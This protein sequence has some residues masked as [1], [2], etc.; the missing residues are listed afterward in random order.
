MI[1]LDLSWKFVVRELVYQFSSLKHP[2]AVAEVFGW[3]YIQIEVIMLIRDWYISNEKCHVPSYIFKFELSTVNSS[4]IGS[5]MIK[6]LTLKFCW[7][8]CD[9]AIS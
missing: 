4:S 3:C 7:L 9:Q 8:E 1:E 5:F 6:V 2:C